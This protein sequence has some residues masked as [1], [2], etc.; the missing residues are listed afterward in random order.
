MFHSQM[1]APPPFSAFLKSI[2]FLKC[3]SE[4]DYFQVVK[5]CAFLQLDG[6]EMKTDASKGTLFSTISSSKVFS[7]AGSLLY[8]YSQMRPIQQ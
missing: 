1:S 8:A 7:I 5:L 3:S 2:V 6:S 4:G